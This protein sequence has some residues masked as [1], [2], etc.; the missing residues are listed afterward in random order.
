M[1]AQLVPQVAV[2]AA[3]EWDSF[4]VRNLNRFSAG[5]WEEAE[6]A[7]DA[8]FI[9]ELYDNITTCVFTNEVYSLDYPKRERTLKAVNQ[10]DWT[11][12]PSNQS[13][14]NK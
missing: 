8:D 1:E 3:V 9:D 6:M 2:S 7:A 5:D 10:S 14:N 11:S 4:S 12:Q 13:I